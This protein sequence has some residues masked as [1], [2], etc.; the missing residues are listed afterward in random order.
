VAVQLTQRYQY[1]A[2]RWQ[3]N[4]RQH[5]EISKAVQGQLRNI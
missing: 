1:M 4:D 3:L 5:V 2:V